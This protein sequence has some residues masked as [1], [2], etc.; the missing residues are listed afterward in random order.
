MEV[1]KTDLVRAT[2]ALTALRRGKYE[3]QGD[4][5]LAFSQAFNWLTELHDRVKLALEVPPPAPAVAA[6]PRAGGRKKE[7]EPAA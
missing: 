3:L 6:V 4:E 5:V 1:T 2:V 7:K